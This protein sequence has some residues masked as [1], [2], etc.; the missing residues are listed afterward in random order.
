[1]VQLQKDLA[2]PLDTDDGEDGNVHSPSKPYFNLTINR[3][4][5]TV[6][7]GWT[8]DPT[9]VVRLCLRS[10][11]AVGDGD[12][13]AKS[14]GELPLPRRQTVLLHRG[15]RGLWKPDQVHP[16]IWQGVSAVL[17]CSLS[18]SHHH[19]HSGV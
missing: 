12:D 14:V 8:M 7:R 17:V 15:I 16:D 4:D 3:G 1:M 9:T 13:Q 11:T 19:T 2:I 10:N 18:L 6:C 5:W